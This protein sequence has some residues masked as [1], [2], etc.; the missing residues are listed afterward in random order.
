[1]TTIPK[2]LVAAACLAAIAAQAQTS[3]YAGEQARDIKSL[4][5][6]EAADL[7]AGQGMG[8]AKA[9]ELNGYPGPAH[10]LEH[11]DALA[12]TPQQRAATQALMAGHKAKAR[13]LGMELV[14][15]E[16]ALDQAFRTRQIDEATLSRLTAE[17]GRKQAQLREEHLRT[18][19]AQTALLDAM[20]VKRYSE[21]RG[22]V[23]ASVEPPSATP[24][25][26]QHKH[27]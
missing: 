19:L 24:P 23:S 10:V 9:A 20:Q 25:A 5:E 1:M 6:R 3:P 4:S 12:L 8:L 14:A 17:I 21:L 26:N 7:L 2:I 15:A 22:Y 11:A 13:A 16:R 18:H 27:H